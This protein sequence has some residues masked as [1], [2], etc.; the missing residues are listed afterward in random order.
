MDLLERRVTLA[1]LA[2]TGAVLAGSAGPVGASA[3]P[4]AGTCI[5]ARVGPAIACLAAGKR[6]NPRYEHVYKLY[7]FKCTRGGDGHYQLHARNYI[8][9]PRP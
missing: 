5:R 7:E 2:A 8:G 9:Q 6:C 1:I 3:A 4:A